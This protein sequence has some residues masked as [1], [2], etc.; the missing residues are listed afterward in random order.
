[1]ESRGGELLKVLWYYN[2]VYDTNSLKQKIICPF[3]SNDINPSLLVDTLDNRWFCFGCQLGG[4]A[5]AFVRLMERKYNNLNDLQSYRKYLQILKSKKCSNI[6]IDKNRIQKI[7][8]PKKQLYN[9]SYDYYHGLKKIDWKYDQ[10]DEVEHAYNYMYKRGYSVETLSKVGAKITYNK[11]YGLIFPMFDNWKFKGW[12]C[13]T[14]DKEIEKK[15]KYLYNDGFQRANTLV[16]TYGMK[17]YVIVVEGYMDRLRF[18]EYGLDDNVVAILGWKMSQQQE[19]KLRDAGVKHI[20][21]CLDNDDCGRKGTLYL[22]SIF[23]PSNVLRWSYIKG[24]KDPGE[25]SRG[26]F[27]KM[28]KRTMDQYKIKFK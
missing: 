12:V 25:M 5:E 1:M 28:Y 26:Q 20:I 18:V 16:G 14:M 2:L 21:S 22:K 23:T 24:I 6:K 10:S 27:D 4:N 7:K 15:R 3:H 17:D 13:R 8:R 19:Q 9:E 11:S